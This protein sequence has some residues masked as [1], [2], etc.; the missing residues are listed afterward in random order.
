MQKMEA[1]GQLTGGI[2]HDFNNMLAIII[3]S[4]DVAKRRLAHDLARAETCIDNA[5][6][7][8]QRAAQLTGR[9]LAFSRQQPLA[10]RV[11]DANKLVGGMSDMLRRSVGEHLKPCWPAGSG[12]PSPTPASWRTRCST[13]ALTRAT[14]CPTAAG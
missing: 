4:L 10:P 5:L 2:A 1:V 6:E 12:P 7:G 13:C 14:P 3:G 11:L 9:L 8:A